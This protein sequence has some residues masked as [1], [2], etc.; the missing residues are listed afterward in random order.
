[1]A[2]E[3]R[4]ID[5]NSVCRSI[6]ESIR[7]TEEWI[8]EV[9]EQQDTIGLQYASNTYSSLIS[10]L[11][12]I[13]KEPTVEVPS[14]KYGR[15]VVSPVQ[16][17]VEITYECSECGHEVVGDYEKTPFCGGCGARMNDDKDK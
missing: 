16:K 9:R 13:Q 2:D 17:H 1:M 3:I 6:V 15:W 14:V 12:R 8:N 7:Y 10:M 11:E 4:L 5:A